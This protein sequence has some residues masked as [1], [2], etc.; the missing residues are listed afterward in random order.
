MWDKLGRLKHNIL[1]KQF[2]AKNAQLHL[3]KQ[4]LE[5]MQI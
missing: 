1:D 2:H 3:N 4:W 5:N